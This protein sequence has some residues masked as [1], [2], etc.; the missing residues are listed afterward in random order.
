MHCVTQ[1]KLGRDYVHPIPYLCR[2][3]DELFEFEKRAIEERG[4]G[5][6]FRLPDS[7]YK[8]GRS[9]LKE[10]YLVKLSRFVRTEATIIGF[11]E[12][13]HNA[14]RSKRNAVGMMD[15]SSRQSG[16]RGKGVLGA[17]IVRDDNGLV[18]NVGTGVGLTDAMREQVWLSQLN[19]LG[20]RITIKHKPHGQK[21]KP[22]SP[23]YVG[24]REKGF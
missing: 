13:M 16:L 5:I 20:A 8:Q 12:Q 17:F 2:S 18:F 11:E 19:W 9:T 7:P 23:I 24:R 21:L 22:R 14:N 4:E 3:A 1:L 10:Q 6:C 15:R